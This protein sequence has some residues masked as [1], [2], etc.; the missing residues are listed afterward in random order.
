MK[1]RFVCLCCLLLL[2]GMNV[3]QT[4]HANGKNLR[5]RELGYSYRE[6]KM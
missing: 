5:N 3:Q 1:K 6:K 2:S 4:S